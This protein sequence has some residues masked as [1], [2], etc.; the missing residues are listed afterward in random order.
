MARGDHDRGWIPTDGCIRAN[1]HALARYAAICQEQDLVPIVEPE[2]LMDA[3]NSI[4][5]C[6]DATARTLH[7]VFAE[8]FEQRVALS[9]ILL[10]PNMVIAGKG[11]SSRR[12]LAG[13]PTHDRDVQAACPRGG[14]R[15]RLP[16]RGPVR[17]RGDA[18]S[19]RDQPPRWPVA[20]PVLLWPRV[21]GVGAP[22]GGGDP[23]NVEAGRQAFAHRA[24][25]N[26]LAVAG[27]WN[28]SWSSRSPPDARSEQHPG[29]ETEACRHHGAVPDE[30]RLHA[31]R[32]RLGVEA[33]M[34]P[35]AGTGWNR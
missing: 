9:G 3:D 4:E 28:A 15:D 23:A 30:F 13:S 22:G 31:P 26:A 27:E 16:L 8:L 34:G 29:H 20:A 5:R 12:T 17:G 19:E 33:A 2:V 25:M 6:H 18:Q 14:A 35:V 32:P 24:R 21:A 1:A 10:K 11:S 7:A